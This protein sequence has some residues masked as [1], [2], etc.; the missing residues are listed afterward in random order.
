VLPG[1]NIIPDSVSSVA[2]AVSPAL[3]RLERVPSSKIAQWILYDFAGNETR[4]DSGS[5]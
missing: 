1:S 2:I 3:G 5:D 4:R